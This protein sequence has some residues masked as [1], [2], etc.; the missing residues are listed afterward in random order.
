M[1]KWENEGYESWLISANHYTIQTK[2]IRNVTKANISELVLAQ[3][4]CLSKLYVQVSWI[5]VFS[6]TV[7]V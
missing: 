3:D 5:P 4:C 7:D 2:P 1:E 6:N